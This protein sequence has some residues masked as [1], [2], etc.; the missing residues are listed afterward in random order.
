MHALLSDFEDV[1]TIAA[2]YIV[3]AHAVDE[4]PVGDKLQI[5]QPTSAA[6]RCSIARAFAKQYELRMP[7]LVDTIDNSFNQTFAAWPIRFFIIHEGRMAY[8]A[9]PDLHNTYDAILPELRGFLTR[10]C[11]SS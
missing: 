3:E 10:L 5:T 11:R 2:V 7:M 1:A 6:E 9:Q 4:W 8:I